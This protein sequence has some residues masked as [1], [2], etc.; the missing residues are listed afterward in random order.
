L[1][2]KFLP[3]YAH[4]IK[5]LIYYRCL[6]IISTFFQ[7]VITR[8]VRIAVVADKYSSK[9]AEEKRKNTLIPYIT[10]CLAD[11]FVVVG[12]TPPY[13][14]VWRKGGALLGPAGIVVWRLGLALIVV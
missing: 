7:S 5:D 6:H 4:G 3:Y 10:F 14:R 8:I 13:F 11:P 2:Q 12:D 9:E 1:E